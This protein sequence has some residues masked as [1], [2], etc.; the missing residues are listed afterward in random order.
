MEL[1]L[2]GKLKVDNSKVNYKNLFRVLYE[3]HE[4][5]PL[6]LPV[7][8]STLIETF[9]TACV[10]N[11]RAADRHSRQTQVAFKKEALEQVSSDVLS[12]ARELHEKFAS[13]EST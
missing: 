8:S 10:F 5:N 13:L 2:D 1:F 9:K 3:L 11:E 6:D 12:A 7:E 4:A